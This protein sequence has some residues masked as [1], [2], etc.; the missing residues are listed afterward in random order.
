MRIVFQ[1]IFAV[2]L[3][4]TYAQDPIEEHLSVIRHAEN[5]KDIYY[6]YSEIVEYYSLFS[7]DSAIFYSQQFV[8]YTDSQSDVNNQIIS[9]CLLS[10]F[11]EDASMYNIALEVSLEAMDLMNARKSSVSPKTEGA[12]YTELGWIY[13]NLDDHEKSLNYFRNSLK[14][15]SINNDSSLMGY[16][17][18]CIGSFYLF[19]E[20]PLFYDSAITYLE[21]ANRLIQESAASFD[22]IINIETELAYAYAYLGLLDQARSAIQT[23]DQKFEKMGPYHQAYTDGARYLVFKSEG[24]YQQALAGFNRLL[25]FTIEMGIGTTEESV[26][27][28]KEILELAKMMNDSELALATYEELRKRENEWLEIQKV[29]RTNELQIQYETAQKEQELIYQANQIKQKNVIIYITSISSLLI[30]L[31]LSVTLILFKKI[32]RKNQQIETL[33][34][35]LHHRVKNN[36]QVI[37]SLLGL[38]SSKLKDESAQKAVEEGKERIRAMSLIHQKL[39]QQSDVSS[40]NLKEYLETLVKEIADSYGYGRKVGLQLEIPE[41]PM[42]VDTTMPIGLIVNEL[43]SN[44]FKY[45]YQDIDQPFLKL[46]VIE[47]QSNSF[48][49]SIKD[50]GKGLPSSFN[51]EKATSFG[52]KLVRLLVKQLGAKLEINQT[53]GLE[54]KIEFQPA[55]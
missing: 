13:D 55:R 40:V 39:Y 31:A 24:K 5:P 34:R 6:A 48:Q 42:D 49:L 17:N 54:Y 46:S 22:S 2:N 43:V 20:N 25:D 4:S 45:A 41:I 28:T 7:I 37:S 8:D 26:N 27:L 44:S 23:L 1:L 38:Q 15:G 18:Y 30:L 35:E 14:I 11:Y 16:G 36:L 33:M 10:S 12:L 53:E 21:T 32:K 3:F 52:L 19:S 29:N 50:N 47:Q 9:R 51:F